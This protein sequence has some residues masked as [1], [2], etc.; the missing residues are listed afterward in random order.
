MMFLVFLFFLF[1]PVFSHGQ[2]FCNFMDEII[3]RSFDKLLKTRK[4]Q[5]DK[6]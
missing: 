4:S 2:L 6:F 3:M 5:P 1:L